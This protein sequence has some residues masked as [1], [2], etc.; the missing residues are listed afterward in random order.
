MSVCIYEHICAALAQAFAILELELQ[1]V[2]MDIG[3]ELW[4]SERRA[5]PLNLSLLS[6]SSPQ[7]PKQFHIIFLATWI[8]DID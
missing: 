3:D 8:G 5:S 2:D 4:S 1:E 6:S 7:F